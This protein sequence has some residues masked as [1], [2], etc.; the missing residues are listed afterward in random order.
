M[1]HLVG[2]DPVSTPEELV[3]R[4]RRLKDGSGLTYRQIAARAREAGDFLPSSTAAGALARGTLPRA[5]LLAA[6]VRACTGDEEAVREWARVRDDVAA[7][8]RRVPPA[9]APVA[10][11][12][13]ARPGAG[14]AA[15]AGRPRWGRPLVALAVTTVC[16]TAAWRMLSVPS[17]PARRGQP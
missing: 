4:M 10:G 8:A 16:G 1:S 5:E 12:V 7:L 14:G 15:S 11:A 3:A 6:F 17:F 9:P 13:A 2:P